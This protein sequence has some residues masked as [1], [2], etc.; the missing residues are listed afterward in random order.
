MQTERALIGM[1]WDA[2]LLEEYDIDRS[3]W[4]G[5]ERYLKDHIRPGGFLSAILQNNLRET[6]AQAISMQAASSIRPIINFLS[7]ECS[8]SVWGSPE[9]F[10]NHL[11][12][13][14]VPR[15]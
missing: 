3:F 10:E 7:F 6:I 13:N 5:L 12:S 15:R 2:E 8:A 1:E 4:G 9:A 14:P 11:A